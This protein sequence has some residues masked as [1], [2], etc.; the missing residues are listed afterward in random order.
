MKR[1]TIGFIATIFLVVFCFF[2]T[3]SATM[4]ADSTL[5]VPKAEIAPVIDGEM[6]EMWYG[7]TRTIMT[8]PLATTPNEPDDWFDNWGNFRMMYDADNIYLFI[9]IY[10]EVIAFDSETTYEQDGVELYFDAD[11]SK[12]QDNF[13]GVDDIQLRF[14]T[15]WTTADEVETGFGS[16]TAWEFVKDDIV[17]AFVL[18]EFGFDLEVSIP[19]GELLIEPEAGWDFGFEIQTNDNDEGARENGWRWWRMSNDSWRWAHLFGTAQLDEY[20]AGEIMRV[21]K[22]TAAPVIDGVMDE[23]WDRSPDFSS[24]V[25]VT[26]NNGEPDENWD[27]YDKVDDWNDMDFDF[28]AMW[29]DDYFYFFANVRDDMISVEAGADHEKDSFELYFDGDNSK[30]EVVEAG[31][32]AYDDNDKQLRAIYTDTPTENIAFAATDLGWDIEW[33]ISYDELGWTPEAGFDIGFDV[34]LNDQDDPADLRSGMARWWSNDNYSWLDPSLFGNALLVL[35]PSAVEKQNNGAI[36]TDYQLAQNY[37][38]PF[39]PTTNIEYAV[40]TTSNVKLTVF[41]MLGKEVATLVNQTQANGVYRVA[42][43]A[44]NLPSGVYFYKLDT[45]SQVLTQKMMLV[46]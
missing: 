45:G 31:V 32:S 2:N 42:F 11:N 27:I 37:P 1:T 22:A 44:S 40:P 3:A 19:I 5:L 41:D 14:N 21:V 30:N 28:R 34:Q 35:E 18:T 43:D 38:N 29:D 16:A 26:Q 23:A 4:T 20:L 6:D 13:D 8:L 12:T 25:Y 33:R 7:V 10:D 24:N 46:K 15:Q 17:Y 9:E 39:N 36:V